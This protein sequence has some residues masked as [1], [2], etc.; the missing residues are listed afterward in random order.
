M[1]ILWLY[2]V[3]LDYVEDKVIKRGQAISV[4]DF[5]RHTKYN[6]KLASHEAIPDLGVIPGV[7]LFDVDPGGKDGHRSSS[8]DV[9]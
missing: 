3:Y 8:T 4:D 1:D 7:I 9:T 6:R 2:G 5:V